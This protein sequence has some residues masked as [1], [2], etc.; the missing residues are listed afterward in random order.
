MNVK[1]GSRS[2]PCQLYLNS[3]SFNIKVYFI[4]LRDLALELA[5][6]IAMPTEGVGEVKSQEESGGVRRMWEELE[7]CDRKS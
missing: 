6:I 2:G 4:S 3:K 7:E 1:L 5:A